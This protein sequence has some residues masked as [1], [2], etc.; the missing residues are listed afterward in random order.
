MTHFGTGKE[1][2][3]GN[4]WLTLFCVLWKFSK[5][6]LVCCKGIVNMSFSFLDLSVVWVNLIN[7]YWLAISKF[8]A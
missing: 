5:I 8:I 7:V 4:I 2:L 6:T 1:S 3:R